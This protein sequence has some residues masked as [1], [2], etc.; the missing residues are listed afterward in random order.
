M[1]SK[2]RKAQALKPRF[3]D[4]VVDVVNKFEQQQ[5][6]GSG[7]N[8]KHAP[9]KHNLVKARNDTGGDL[10]RGSVVDVATS[11]LTGLSVFDP[12]NLWLEGTEQADG[13]YAV[14]R[15]PV[16]DGGIEEAQLTGVCIARVNVVDEDHTFAVPTS[17]QNYFTSAAEGEIQILD[18]TTSGTSVME[19]VV[20]LRAG[21]PSSHSPYWVRPTSTVAGYDHA[22]GYSTGTF[23]YQNIST[24]THKQVAVTTQDKT[25]YNLSSF[26]FLNSEQGMLY[27]LPSGVYVARPFH[28]LYRAEYYTAQISTLTTTPAAFSFTNPS[29]STGHNIAEVDGSDPTQINFLAEATFK[30]KMR[31]SLDIGGGTAHD[32]NVFFLTATIGGGTSRVVADAFNGNGALFSAPM[33]YNSLN[34]YVEF[35]AYFKLLGSATGWLNLYGS[36][37]SGSTGTANLGVTIE[38]VSDHRG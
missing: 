2:N 25:A 13:H 11:I 38:G 20:V 32:H 34:N 16:L 17:G 5:R 37:N 4:R 1:K 10:A 18:K 19:C 12:H 6:L 3:A 29:L 26:N 15:K 28:P 33:I 23:R 8:P 22:N 7:G 21:S 30:V 9:I 14:F 24:S 27:Q 31:V 36:V 35:D